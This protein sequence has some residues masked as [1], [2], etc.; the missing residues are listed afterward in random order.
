MGILITAVHIVTVTGQ[1]T[2]IYVQGRKMYA[3]KETCSEIRVEQLSG[4]TFF[5]T[6]YSVT[7]TGLI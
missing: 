4:L 2:K 7:V 5:F 6:W 3:E 1:N